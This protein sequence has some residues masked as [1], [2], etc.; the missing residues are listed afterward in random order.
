MNN[1]AQL[2]GIVLRC[3]ELILFRKAL[4]LEFQVQ[5]QQVN[6]YRFSIVHYIK[7]TLVIL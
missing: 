1:V 3:L 5:Y 7:N 6:K 2:L 4:T